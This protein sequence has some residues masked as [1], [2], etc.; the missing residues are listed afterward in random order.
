[1]KKRLLSLVALLLAAGGGLHPQEIIVGTGFTTRFDNREYSGNTFDESKTLFSARLSPRVGV[2]W[3]EKNRLIIGVDLLQ[4]FGDDKKFLTRARP[5]LYYSFRTEN[6]EAY[7]GVFDRKA[8]TGDYS[9]A[10]FSDSLAFYKN[11][12]AGFLGAYR[13]TSRPKTYVEFGI[14]W[15]GIYGKASREKFRILSAGRYTVCDSFYFGYAF[16]MFHFAS[17]AEEHNVSDNM[18]F[19]PFAGSEFTAFFD[20]DVKL[21]MLLAPQRVRRFEE[22]WKKPCGGQLDFKMTR[23]GVKIENT[24]FVGEN[25]MPYYAVHG[26]ELYSGERFYATTEHVYNRTSIGYER[27]F[28]NRSVTVEACMIFHYDG[29]GLGNQQVV[30]LSV[31][32]EKIFNKGRK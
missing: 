25:L 11:R 22:G 30:R 17:S 27:S 24:L 13:S 16:S 21:G 1:M 14:D 12:M 29:T 2:Q 15:E 9:K 10:F 4:D 5:L 18:L 7:A 28:F 26:S 31:D 32:I 3:A 6:V 23:W 8:L 19:N 20:F